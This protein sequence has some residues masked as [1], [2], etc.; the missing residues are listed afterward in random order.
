MKLFKSKNSLADKYL[1]KEVQENLKAAFKTLPFQVPV[2]L[3]YEEGEYEEEVQSGRELIQ[4]LSEISDKVT[5]E[6]HQLGDEAS[7][8]WGVARAPALVFA[9]DRYRIHYLGVPMGEEG[10]TLVETLVLCSLGRSHLGD[11]AGKV[12]NRIDTERKI[13]VFVS[14]SC[15]YCP[16]QAVNGV[17]AAIEKPGLISVEIIDTDFNN[18]LAE[19]YKAYSV[20]QTYAN[21]IFIGNGAQ[22][23]E[24]FAVSLEALEVQSYYIP[25][26]DAPVVETDLVIIGGGPAGLT[27]G[28]YAARSGLNAVIVERENLGG[29]VADTPVVENYPG[30]VRIGGKNL[31]D[32]MVQHALQ[33][34]RIF[35]REAVVDLKAGDGFEVTTTRRKFKSRAVLMATGASHKKLNAR[36]E[37]RFAGRGV[38]YCST[39]DGPLFKGKKVGIVGGGDSAVTE[40][41]HL[42]HIGVDIFLIH[43]RDELRAQDYL[44]HDLVDKGIPVLWN[45][46]VVEIFGQDKV[47]KVS[48]FNNRTEKTSEIDVDG[49]FAAIGYVP[50]VELAKKLGVEIT[51]EGYIKHDGRHR[52]NIRGIYSAGDVEGGYKQIVTATGA[53]AGAAMTIFED[54]T[55]PY[56]TKK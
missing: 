8:E 49:L 22:P 13:K 16:Q 15:P 4:A 18:D 35:P 25:D 46:E 42:H 55:H 53:G 28:I 47:E 48:I 37:E 51:D 41:L 54:L 20:P 40:A 6:E 12:I 7:E 39:C 3:F 32:I 14:P 38:S 33:Y 52:T 34:S 45:S 27:A 36:G 43:R 5:L 9:P 23:E 17:K 24:L 11:Q 19:L 29:Q 44:V 10:R 31:V 21:D 50:E 56:W 30:L 2:H 26:D 1:P